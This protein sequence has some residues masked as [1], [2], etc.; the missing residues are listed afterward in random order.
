[1][2]DKL[3]KLKEITDTLK[4]PDELGGVFLPKGY[5][6]R[7]DIMFVAEMPSMN[8][9]KEGNSRSIISILLNGINFSKR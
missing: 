1:M 6:E 3:Y 8:E 9:P 2:N 4:L 5:K 7:F